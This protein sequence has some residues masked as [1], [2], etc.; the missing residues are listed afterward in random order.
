MSWGCTGSFDECGRGE[1]GRENVDPGAQSPATPAAV[2]ARP[3]GPGQTHDYRRNGS[4]S[5]CAA[6][7]VATGTVL[8]VCRARYTGADF[9]AFL[10]RVTRAYRGCGLHVILDNSSTHST[11]AVHAW[12][13]EHPLFESESQS[14]GLGNPYL[15][16]Q[17]WSISTA[18]SLVAN[19]GGKP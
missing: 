8:G 13:A 3:A 10:T 6:L 19:A 18:G 17:S 7:E 16:A 4:T 1:P 2:A 9:V 14:L 5:L 12:L 15:G 11:S